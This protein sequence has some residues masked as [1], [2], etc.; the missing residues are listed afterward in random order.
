MRTSRLLLLSCPCD[1]ATNS[2][3]SVAVQGIG[4]QLV[5]VEVCGYCCG[6]Y[7][8]LLLV[9]DCWLFVC[10]YVYFTHSQEGKLAN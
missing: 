6:Y 10:M 1:R 7:R 9:A 4:Y 2:S 3:V 8:W 5:D